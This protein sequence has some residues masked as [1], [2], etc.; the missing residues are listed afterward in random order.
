M[1]IKQSYCGL[2][3][4]FFLLQ[5]KAEAQTTPQFSAGYDPLSVGHKVTDRFIKS[6]HVLYGATIA[7]SE[8]CTWYGALKFAEVSKNPQ[9]TT[10][11][12]QRYASFFGVDKKLMPLHD[13]VDHSVFGAL[14]LELYRQTKDDRY[15][16]TGKLYADNQWTVP[17]GAKLTDSLKNFVRKGHSWHTRLWIDDMYMITLLQVQAFRV[18]GNEMY[19]KR[20]AKEMV[21]YL[22]ELQKPNGL[23]YHAPDVPFYW[24]RG[25]GWMAAGMTEM[26]K[27]LPLNNPDRPFILKGYQTMMKSLLKYQSDGGMWRQ[28]ID[29]SGSWPESSSTGMFTYAMIV[30]AKSG[31]LKDPKYLVAAKKGWKSLVDQISEKGDVKEVCEGT[32]KEND[33][34]YYLDRKRITGDFHGQ[35]PV[36]WCAFAW[37]EK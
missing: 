7:Y 23:F 21:F 32:N 20:A 36:L 25:N 1:K 37:L 16:N 12:V 33:R 17:L 26:L 18:T 5:N 10:M 24:G 11:L 13:N 28:L 29:D 4:A 34:Q 2:F 6:A 9:K 3:I 35:A 31:W 30:G 8:V 27:S 15:L 22:K 14:P 19:I